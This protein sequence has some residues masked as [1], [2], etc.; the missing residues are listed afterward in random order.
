M[1]LVKHFD[2][3][4]T[5]SKIDSRTSKNNYLNNFEISYKFKMFLFS[6]KNIKIEF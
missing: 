3:M 1:S 6:L 5:D 4:R 2:S